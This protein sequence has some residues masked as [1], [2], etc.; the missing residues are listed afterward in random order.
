MSRRARPK[1]ARVAVAGEHPDDLPTHKCGHFGHIS[2]RTHKLCRGLVVTGT[3]ACRTHAG[4]ALDQHRAEGQLRVEYSKWT[5]DGHD[6]S[7]I[8]PKVEILRLIAFW[9]YR[10][11]MYGGLVQKAY[12]AAERMGLSRRSGERSGDEIVTLNEP[13]W[14]VDENGDGVLSEHPALQQARQ[15]LETIFR[16]GGIT[17]FVGNKYDVDSKGRIYAVDEGVRA[18]MTLE[19]DAHGM[20]AKFCALAIQA[21]VAESRIQ[22]AEQVGVMIQAVILGV[23]RDLSIQADD[24]VM[25]LIAANIDMVSATPALTAA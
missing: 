21:K 5:L 7:N 13:Q 12:E 2:K 23:L 10:C 19:K 11:N 6:G 15:D 3:Q 14:E 22:L 25:D 17:A 4:K 24:R 8:D 16:Q 1:P 20:L 9:K 18:L